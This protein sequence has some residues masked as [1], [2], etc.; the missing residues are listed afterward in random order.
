MADL[1]GAAYSRPATTP[2]KRAADG[3]VL[4]RSTNRRNRSRERSINAHAI[5]AEAQLRPHLPFQV[6]VRSQ[7]RVGTYPPGQLNVPANSRQL[8]PR[9]ALLPYRLSNS[10][11][12]GHRGPPSSCLCGHVTPP[13]SPSTGIGPVR[14]PLPISPRVNDSAHPFGGFGFSVVHQ[15]RRLHP[16]RK[17]CNSDRKLAIN[18]YR[19]ST[20]C[21]VSASLWS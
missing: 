16:V 7:Q 1:A 2:G 14:L 10:A 3:R 18:R 17:T 15:V 12:H 19:P 13:S 5:A 6:I 20:R 11:H 8:G 4:P 21:R 9:G